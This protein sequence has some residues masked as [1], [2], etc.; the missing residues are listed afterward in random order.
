MLIVVSDIHSS[1]NNFMGMEILQSKKLVLND[2]ATQQCCI[3]N[4]M[5]TAVL[6]VF[7][8]LAS[9][10]TISKSKQRTE[11]HIVCYREIKM[12]DCIVCLLV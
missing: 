12:Y 7:G 11:Y 8:P 5:Y 3:H 1:R 9:K 10:E 2:H 6:T 4:T